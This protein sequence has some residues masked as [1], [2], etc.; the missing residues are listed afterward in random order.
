MSTEAMPH[1]RASLRATD[2]LP[3]PMK[4]TKNTG[5]ASSDTMR[6]GRFC[7]GRLVALMRV[8]RDSVRRRCR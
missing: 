7:E 3:A 6:A 5:F 1:V 2:V 4:P 8:D